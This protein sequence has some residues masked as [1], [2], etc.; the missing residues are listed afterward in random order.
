MASITPCTQMN[1]ITLWVNKGS[2]GQ[3]ECTLQAAVSAVETYLQDTG[4]RLSPL[5]SELLVY[6]S[7]RRPKPTAE[8]RQCDDIILYTQDGSC[9]PRVPKI[10]ILGMHI[11]AN[12]SNIEAIR[13]IEGKVTAAT[14]LIKR[15]TNKHTGMKEDSVMR[16]I[17]SFAISHITYVAAF[18]NWNVT[19]REKI[20]TLIRKTYKIA[21]GLPESTSTAR[22]LQLGVY[23]TLEEIVDA[24][25]T[26]QLERMSLTATGRYIL[27]KLGFNY[28]VQHGQKQV[29]P[30]DLSDTLIVTPIPRNMHPEFNRGRRQARAKALLRSLGGKRTTRFVDAAEYAR[31]HRFTAVVVDVSSRLTH[32][33]SVA[34]EFP[35]TAEEVAI[36]LALTDPLCEVVF[37][38]SQSTVRNYARG[39]ISSEALQILRKAGRQH[40]DNT[41]IIW[42]PARVATPTDEG[43][44]N[45]NEVAHR[46][47]REL[48]RRTESGTASSSSELLAQSTRER[49]VR[50]NDIT[51][52]YQLGRRLLPPPHPMLKRR[53]AVIWR[54]LQTQTFPSPVR[55]QHIFPAQ[56][57]NA[58]CKLCQDTR[59][60]LSHMLWECRVTSAT[61]AVAPEAL[62][63]KWAAALRSSNLKTQEWAVQQAREA[64]TRHGLEVPSWET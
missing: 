37:S 42:F 16:L 40:F 51:K 2:D 54:Q 24:Q 15:I 44:I 23:N 62:A 39:R 27:W 11:T 38:D 28:H 35:E 49:L 45:L 7:R 55:L 17:Q 18:H 52:H 4:L 48:T 30:P 20:N 31:E 61:M 9:I 63:S 5:K 50:Y 47:A 36:A 32:A 60:T 25:R 13:K 64:A 59:A 3:I 43:L 57:P 46:S 26:S 8:S 12:G 10:R 1:D 22:L 33:C 34:T 21:L 58:L 6:R 29:I 53:Q 14:R 19:E 41:A 56:Y